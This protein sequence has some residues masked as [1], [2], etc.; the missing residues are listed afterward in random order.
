MFW[1]ILQIAW[2]QTQRQGSRFW[3]VYCSCIQ[4]HQGLG[5]ISF[6]HIYSFQ[7]ESAETETPFHSKNDWMEEEARPVPATQYKYEITAGYSGLVGRSWVSVKQLQISDWHFAL[8]VASLTHQPV[9]IHA[10]DAADGDHLGDGHSGYS[11]RLSSFIFYLKTYTVSST[12]NVN[13][14]LV[15]RQINGMAN[16]D[17]SVH[18]VAFISFS[19]S[20]SSFQ[21]HQ[22]YEM[23]DYKSCYY[24]RQLRPHGWLTTF[25]GR[26][27][28]FLNASVRMNE[29]MLA[30]C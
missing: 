15:S 9:W 29:V 18:Y 27:E 20:A 13:A 19:D 24:Q 4:T 25:K 10:W 8:L 21:R 14:T 12:I 3:K 17:K 22:M 7:L 23:A 28:H 11:I 5:S 26:L 16:A 2:H 30:H 1:H 6:T